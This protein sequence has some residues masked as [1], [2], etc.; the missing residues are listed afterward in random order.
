MLSCCIALRERLHRGGD[1]SAGGDCGSCSVLV[2]RCRC[3]RVWLLSGIRQLMRSEVDNAI[4]AG[5][6]KAAEDV[7]TL[8]LTSVQIQAEDG[9]EDEQHHGKVKHNH[10]GRLRR[11]REKKSEKRQRTVCEITD[12]LLQLG[13]VSDHSPESKNLL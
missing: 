4:R 11:E 7:Q 2:R 1:L 5:T 3:G 9:R 10:N 13:R 6:V 12:T 8:V